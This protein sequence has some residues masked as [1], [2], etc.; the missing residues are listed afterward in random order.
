[1]V[2][3]MVLVVI[4]ILALA[5]YSF[6]ELMLG[7]RRAAQVSMQQAQA[8]ALADSGMELARRFVL[9]DLD[10]QIQLGGCYDNPQRFRGVLVVDDPRTQRRGRFAILSPRLDGDTMTGVRYGLEDEST[11]WNLN[12]LLVLDKTAKGGARQILMGLPGMTEDVADA[13]LDWMDP[14]DQPREFGAEVD[15]YSGQSPPYAPKNGPLETVEELLLLRGITPGLL[16]GSDAKRNGLPSMIQSVDPALGEVD[17]SDGS[18][19]RGWAAYLTLYSLENNMRADGTARINLNGDDLQQL[20]SDLSQAL[21]NDAWATFIVA[22]RLFGP[23]KASGGAQAKGEQVTSDHYNLLDL[24]QKGKTKLKTIVDLIGA[25][26]Q[27]KTN[28]KSSGGSSKQSSQSNQSKTIIL[29]SP[30]AN[31][32]DAIDS[33]IATLMDNVTAN[34]AKVIPGRIN[35]NQASRTVLSGIPGMTSD[36]V[37]AIISQRTLDLAQA[38]TSR[39][40]ETWILSEGL[41]TLTQIKSLMPYICARGSVYR[42]QAVGYFEGGGPAVRIEFVLDATSRPAKVLFWRDLS[43]LGRGYSLETLGTESIDWQ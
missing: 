27:V 37:D 2:L 40:Y 17:N 13:I 25:Q 33:Y 4:T 14:D 32:S 10:T 36:V 39:R 42:A 12:A 7:E 19:N 23:Y 21:G 29:E 16:F 28:S 18:M 43:H 20:Y 34:T 35:I 30:F 15:S 8:R 9:Q 24:T 1:M 31:E 26:V 3:V 6:S 11:R 5:G 38:E 41:V 22:Y